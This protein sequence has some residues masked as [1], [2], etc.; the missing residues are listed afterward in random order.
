MTEA[1]TQPQSE[2]L[3]E[4]QP[5]LAR[6][7]VLVAPANID[8]DAFPEFVWAL[9]EAREKAGD[10]PV[11][12]LCRGNDGWV[13]TAL[14]I[15]D[16]IRQDGN[17]H[18]YLMGMCASGSGLIWAACSKRFVYPSAFLGVHRSVYDFP[19]N[20]ATDA[21]YASLVNR[22][23]ETVDRRIAE[24]YAEISATSCDF[25]WWLQ[26]LSKAMLHELTVFGA[27]ELVKMEMAEYVNG[28]T[29][30]T[31]RLSAATPAA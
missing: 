27:A 14:G 10:Q 21:R 7:Q 17:V 3:A 29:P 15:Y 20:H 28:R 30:F 22:R 26:Q 12:L 8:D 2:K 1:A 24:I 5:M 6:W 23:L 11:H 4:K 31:A 18:G 13:E 9:A 16:V 19:A 25:N